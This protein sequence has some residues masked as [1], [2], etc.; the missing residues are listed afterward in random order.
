M[1]TSSASRGQ[2]AE[3]LRP[4]LALGL[5]PTRPPLGYALRV[6]AAG[7]ILVLLP[8]L[9]LA[10]VLACAAGVVWW[11]RNGLDV[12]GD[13]RGRALA[14]AYAGP[15]VSGIVVVLALAKPLVA[16]RVR[17]PEPVELS[18]AD[19][20]VF[21]DVLRQTC[22]AVGAPVPH[23][24]RIDLRV[25]AAAGLLVPAVD[26]V[27]GRLALYLGLP[28]VRGLS[29]RQFLG[30]LAHELG[31]CRQAL[32]LRSYYLSAVVHGWFFEVVHR[33]DRFDAFLERRRR[34]TFLLPLAIWNAA[35]GC[36][37]V[38]RRIL[39][40]L[41]AVGQAVSASLS[42][43]MEFDADRQALRLGGSEA[44]SAGMEEIVLLDAGSDLANQVQ[45]STFASG[46]YVTDVARLVADCRRKLTDEQVDEIL[47]SA[48]QGT[49]SM[50]ASHP[51]MRE[52]L[53]QAEDLGSPGCLPDDALLD[54]SAALLF[55]DLD[56]LGERVLTPWLE[57]VAHGDGPQLQP[58]TSADLWSELDDRRARRA[59]ATKVFLH[60]GVGPFL[61]A[62]DED[63][64]H[65]EGAP[66][67]LLQRLEGARES[68]E[69]LRPQLEGLFARRDHALRRATG[70]GALRFL[71]AGQLPVN[72]QDFEPLGLDP[73]LDAEALAELIPAE[74]RTWE[75]L[76]PLAVVLRERL[77]A[78]EALAGA[79]RGRDEQ[80]AELTARLTDLRRWTSR[81]GRD[82]SFRSE[83]GSLEVALQL[84]GSRGAEPKLQAAAALSCARQHGHLL[85]LRGRL[86]GLAFEDEENGERLARLHGLLQQLPPEP[87][88]GL[89]ESVEFYPLALAVAELLAELDEELIVG[90]GVTAGALE[91]ALSRGSG[92]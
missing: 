5:D 72:A 25:N 37:W 59:A 87:P 65:L 1:S 39:Q 28:L 51:P 74:E 67:E 63:V 68:L 75:A 6:A 78:L 17:R 92:G 77:C 21:F 64:E 40:G 16:L 2:V 56:A 62:F 88:T 15:L 23:S 31:H 30:V 84:A 86:D 22:A 32:G 60:E 7:G 89:S 53:A 11:A 69:Q 66:R 58:C 19:A 45:E 82:R 4:H 8:L 73:T 90:A 35:A 52:R 46:R 12:L 83:V 85:V 70:A 76:E 3:L 9:Y 81:V 48:L 80:R 43:Q 50:Y 27:R 10:L 54:E 47:E 14:L 29:V 71:R 36:V 55:E 18:E 42:R 57:A 20:P 13:V 61:L 38:S 34:S 49:A 41:L 79:V 91:A 24:V 33:R 26:V 44:F